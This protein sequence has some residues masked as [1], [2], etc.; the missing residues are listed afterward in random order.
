M[1][2]LSAKGKKKHFHELHNDSTIADIELAVREGFESVEHLKR[3]TTTGMGTDQG[4]TV[5]CQCTRRHGRPAWHGDSGNRN[6]D[7]SSLPTRPSPSGLSS[8]TTDGN[9]FCKKRKTPIHRWHDRHGAVYEGCGR[10]E[11]SPGTFPGNKEDMHAAVTNANASQPGLPWG[12][13]M[14]PHWAK[15]D[16]QGPDCKPLLNML[17]TNA[18]DRLMP[19]KMPDMA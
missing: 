4:K 10:L 15:I 5:Q 7:I 18:W 6:H 13:W 11:T 17:Y 19:G 16:L 14:P 2:I 12:C 1:T 3:Y 8:G 9:C